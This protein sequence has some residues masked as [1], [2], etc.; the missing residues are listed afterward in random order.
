M[1]LA[2]R[3]NAGFAVYDVRHDQHS[4]ERLSL[5]SQL[6]KAVEEDELVL[7]YQPKVTLVAP[8]GNYAEALVRWRH[9]QRGFIPPGQFIPFA[10]QT[11]YIKAITQW[12]MEK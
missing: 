11:G 1:Y 12:I 5:M 8:H 3:K 7:Y 6:Q 4:A 9:P 2:K 10:E